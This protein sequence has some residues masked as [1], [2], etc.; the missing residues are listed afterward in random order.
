MK[1]LV[2]AQLPPALVSFLRNQGHEADHA[3]DL[4]LTASDDSTIWRQACESGA[5]IITKDEDFKDRVLLSKTK[6]AV[7][8]I[9]VGNCSNR[10]LLLWFRPALPGIIDRLQQGES[11]IELA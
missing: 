1:F 6:A 11:L 4:G 3:A 7:V 9:R 8:L 2:D 10:A 5:V